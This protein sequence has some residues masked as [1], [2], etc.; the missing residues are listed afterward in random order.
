M[1]QIRRY[2]IFV[3]SSVLFCLAVL[4]LYPHYKY[5]ID[6]DGV[7]YLT[8]SGRYATGDYWKAVNGYWSPWSCWMTALVQKT[9]LGIMQSAVVVNVVAGV[10]WLGLLDNFFDYFQLSRRVK[11]AF[12]SSMVVFL[13]FAVFW[14]SFDDLW[15]CA[16]LLASM[17][18]LLTSGYL[19]KPQLWILNGI[20]GG[21]AYYSKAYAFPFFIVNTICC[22]WLLCGAQ[23]GRR[24]LSLTI[25]LSAFFLL[26]LPWVIVLHAKYNIWT[27]STAGGLNMS[28][29]LVGHP[30]WRVGIGSLIPPVYP[31][32]PYYWEDPYFANG[33][34]PHFWSS[35]HLFGL[36]IVRVGLNIGKLLVSVLQLGA[37]LFLAVYGMIRLARRYSRAELFR[38]PGFILLVSVF[39][40]PLG[41]V[42]I[43]FESRYLWYILIPGM[44]ISASGLGESFWPKYVTTNLR[45][46]V[47]CLSMTIFPVWGLARMYDEGKKEHEAGWRMAVSGIKGTFISGL[48]PRLAGRLAYFSGC[49]YFYDIDI[50]RGKTIKDSKQHFDSVVQMAVIYGVQ[51]YFRTSD[52]VLDAYSNVVFPDNGYYETSSAILHKTGSVPGVEI[53]QIVPKK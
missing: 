19:F 49:N 6:P 8:I 1:Q 3:F 32:S 45:L 36:Q 20:L 2:D 52:S 22:V 27:T 5:Y 18:V 48:H 29:Y 14:Q 53:W 21:L 26:V 25:S 33:D 4:L 24:V 16:F 31:D 39:I 10:C 9:G 47:I 15:E 40:F 35:W 11:I 41:Y 43:N 44:V 46:S 37:F 42:L 38:I 17:R 50:T 13:L 23:N 51:Y 12:S 34:T 7:A 30:I 28:W